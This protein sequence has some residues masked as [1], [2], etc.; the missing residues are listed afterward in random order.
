MCMYM[1]LVRKSIRH[2]IRGFLLLS[3]LSLKGIVM[4][5]WDVGSVWLL[6]MF[7]V[8]HKVLKTYVALLMFVHKLS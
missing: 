7:L 4:V 1:D 5:F 3:A 2:Q 8:I 6:I